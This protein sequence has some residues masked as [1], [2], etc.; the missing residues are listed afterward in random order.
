MKKY[1]LVFVLAVNS[2]LLA[3]AQEDL[4]FTVYG[5]DHMIGVVLPSSW[6]VDMNLARVIRMNAFFY[7][8]RY[9]VNTAPVGI[10]LALEDKDGIPSFDAWVE[11]KSQLYARDMPDL[12]SDK[13]SWRI[14]R[15]NNDRVIVEKFHSNKSPEILYS[16]YI[17]A[18]ADFYVNLLMQVKEKKEVNIRQLE[19]EFK[20]CLEK[21]TISGI[22]MSE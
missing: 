21:T 8:R 7:P 16:A 6:N 13:L 1:C 12:K 5:S 3:Q 22:G 20:N 9:T 4:S 10:L 14:T 19:N 15:E 11:G 17:D 2:F 18:G